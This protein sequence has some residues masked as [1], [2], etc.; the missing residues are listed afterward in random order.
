MFREDLNLIKRYLSP[1][2]SAGEVTFVVVKR[3]GHVLLCLPESKK[4]ARLTLDLYQPQKWKGKVLVMLLRV[5]IAMGLHYLLPKVKIP[6][7]GE[8]VIEKSIGHGHSQDFGLLLGSVDSGNRNLI[9][10][11]EVYGVRQVVKASLS[12]GGEILQREYALM[13]DATRFGECTIKP[14]R[15]GDF[16]GGVYYTMPYVAGSGPKSNAEHRMAMDVLFS[17]LNDADLKCLRD[18]VV[19]GEMLAAVDSADERAYFEQYCDK[20]VRSPQGHGDF[21]TWN[22]KLSNGQCRVLDW[23][24]AHHSYVPCWDGIH[25]WLQKWLLCDGYTEE[26]AYVEVVDWLDSESMESYVD[27]AGVRG[28]QAALLGGYLFY[29]SLVCGYRR[30]R[31]IALWAEENLVK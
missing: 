26:Q 21:V 9:I 29:S 28:M 24:S 3:D 19:W 17:W 16:F 31:M 23:E 13:L 2:E 10:A 4:V 8:G 11:S 22:M 5:A 27:R 12:E 18:I 20:L 14:D 25:Y 15:L 7:G 6:V 1:G 30:E